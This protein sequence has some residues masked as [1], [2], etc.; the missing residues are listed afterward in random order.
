MA[1]TD[2]NARTRL[3]KARADMVVNHPFFACLAMRLTLKEDRSCQTAWTDGKTFG[4]NPDYINILPRDKLLGLSAHTVMHPACGHHLRRENRDP[5]TWNKA[6][7]YVINP[8]LIDAGLVL[9]DGFLWDEAHAGKTAEQVYRVLKEGK[10]DDQDLEE[11]N[12]DAR[13]TAVKNQED[14]KDPDK[15]EETAPETG[16]SAAAEEEQA[17]SAGPGRFR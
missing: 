14:E 15:K 12:Q 2:Q 1:V 11:E 17:N 9:P 8:I 10:A 4:Y 6:C 3:L 16:D 7:D 13:A 5:G